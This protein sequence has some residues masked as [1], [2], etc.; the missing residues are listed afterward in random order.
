MTEVDK[1][2]YQYKTVEELELLRMELQKERSIARRNKVKWGQK[3]TELGE[4]FNELTQVLLKK[5][6]KG[7]NKGLFEITDHALLRY[8]ERISEAKVDIDYYKQ[9]LKLKI[10]SALKT[11]EKIQILKDGDVRVKVEGMELWIRDGRVT[12]VTKNE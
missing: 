1:S 11:K 12:T 3:Y 10:E 8:I 2:K 7:F 6:N 4:R 5:K 9:E